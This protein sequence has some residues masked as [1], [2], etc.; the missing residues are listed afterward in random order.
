ML[1]WGQSQI[2]QKSKEAW[3]YEHLPVLFLWTDVFDKNILIA[4]FIP[5]RTQTGLSVSRRKG[6]PVF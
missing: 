1:S 4:D 3:F 5:I 6:T 2:N